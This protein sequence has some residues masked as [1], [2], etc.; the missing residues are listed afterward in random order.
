MGLVVHMLFCLYILSMDQLHDFK[1]FSHPI[2]IEG[3]C[4]CSPI[5]KI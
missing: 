3:L 4:Q 1:R 5:V 2:A